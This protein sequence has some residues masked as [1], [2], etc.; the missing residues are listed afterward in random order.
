MKN[1]IYKYICS[2]L[3]ILLITTLLIGCS[4]STENV[5]LE[6]DHQEEEGIIEFTQAQFDQAGIKI[7]KVQKHNIGSE[8]KVN[9]II[10]VPPHGNISIN[11][12][13]GGFLR[14]TK[15]LSGTIVKKGELLAIVENPDFI[16]FQQEYQE[17]LIQREFLK[18]EYDRQEGLFKKQVASGKKYQQAKS[19]YYSNEVRI[20]A[21]E[22][23]LKLI[24]FDVNSIR[25]GK[26]TARVS[27]YSPISGSVKEVYAN[28][29][30]Y[31]D[32][33]D[34]IMDLTDTADLHA[35]L[36]VYENDIPKVSNGQT[37]RF[38]V[39]NSP[40]KVREAE[41]FLVGKSV[42]EDRSVTVHG[43]LKSKEK[44]LLPGMYISA[45]IITGS[46]MVWAV[47]EEAVVRF[48]GQHYIYAYIGKE[49]EDNE[50]KYQFEMLEINRGMTQ[51]GYVQVDYVKD[52][53]KID[54]V[55]IVLKGAFYILSKSKNSENAGHGH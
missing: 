46:N 19:T 28:V 2:V 9:G 31:I 22:E 33:H 15:M 11:L 41:V 17:G 7:G 39:A 54:S 26:T 50:T 12:P 10:D 45:N 8:L 37:I 1:L 14:S 34:V 13:Y 35:E 52:D 49:L 53:T 6:E 23:K 51:G 43:H 30:K 44:D 25:E 4:A 38:T 42:R 40:E 27:I 18:A 36:S 5:E 32:P 20:K 21:M 24:G 29:G 16:Q 47:P 3:S 48:Q 55:E